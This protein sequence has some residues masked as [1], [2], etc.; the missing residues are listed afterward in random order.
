MS[1]TL[2]LLLLFNLLRLQSTRTLLLLRFLVHV[3]RVKVCVNVKDLLQ[4]VIVFLHLLLF[5]VFGLHPERHLRVLAKLKEGLS[6]VRDV[7]LGCLVGH[8][9]PIVLVLVV[10]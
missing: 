9:I 6:P 4:R 7:D 5:D 2:V 1:A 3:A 10:S 8:G